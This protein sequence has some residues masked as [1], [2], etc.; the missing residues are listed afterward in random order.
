L[1]VTSSL[2]FDGFSS[3]EAARGVSFVS[4]GWF[5][6]A[7]AGSLCLCRICE[8]VQEL[9]PQPRRSSP[10]GTLG[11]NEVVFAEQEAVIS[12]SHCLHF[13]N[14]DALAG[15]C[16]ILQYRNARGI[17]LLLRKHSKQA[18]KGKAVCFWWWSL[19]R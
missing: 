8:V 2:K 15:K 4:G 6:V 14:G 10:Q 1:A 16:K 18:S 17:P 7:C 5:S 19:I 11:C 9:V 13:R 3:W 12:R